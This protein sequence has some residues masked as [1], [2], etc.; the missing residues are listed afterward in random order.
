M[1]R[2]DPINLAV[3]VPFFNEGPGAA[4][5]LDRLRLALAVV[6]RK[7]LVRKR[8]SDLLINH[9]LP[10]EFVLRFIA[11]ILPFSLMFTIPWGFLT[12]VLLVFGKMSA[13]N[14][15]VALRSN[16]V[17]IPRICLPLLFLAIVR[18]SDSY[19]AA[20]CVSGA[21]TLWRSLVLFG[22]SHRSAR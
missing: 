19:A 2:D 18:L 8:L 4:A 13:E 21:L 7:N 9:N 10:V 15:L 5:F 16:G 3:V 20:Y 22:P 14:E 17:S 6:E 12:A 1:S 11:Y